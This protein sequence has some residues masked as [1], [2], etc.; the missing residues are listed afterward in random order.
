LPNIIINGTGISGFID[1]GRA[2]IS[3]PYQDIALAIRSLRFNWGDEYVKSMVKAYGIDEP[4]WE[5]VEFY[6]LL[7]EFF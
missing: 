2:G 7:D 3:D 6:I 4:D 5:K 1:W